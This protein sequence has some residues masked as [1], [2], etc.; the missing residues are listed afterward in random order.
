MKNGVLQS[1]VLSPMLLNIY[2]S[3][4]PE[5][6]RKY[7]YADDLVILL[8]RPPCKEMELGLNTNMTILLE[9]IRNWCLQLIVGKSVSAASHLNNIEAKRERDVFVDNIRPV[10]QQ[11]PNYLG[12]RLDRMLNVKQYVEE[13][14]SKVTSRVSL[15]RRL[16]GTTWGAYT[17]TLGNTTQALVFS[18]VEKCAHIWNRNL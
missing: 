13:M 2:I 11:A 5:T 12:V 8:Q 9:Y 3:D 15:I 1:S 4:L 18:A 16:A 17:K 6:E 7:G 14:T 10:F